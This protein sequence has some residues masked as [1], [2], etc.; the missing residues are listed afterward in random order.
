ML[1]SIPVQV[2]TNDFLFLSILNSETLGIIDIKIFT[3][4]KLLYCATLDQIIS[5]PTPYCSHLVS[6]SVSSGPPWE[7]QMLVD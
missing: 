7:R 1:C 4:T 5:F 6:I 3:Y 2:I